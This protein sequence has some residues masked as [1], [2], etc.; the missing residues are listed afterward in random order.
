MLALHAT[1]KIKPGRIDEF[2]RLLGELAVATRAEPGNRLYVFG[3]GPAPD[4]VVMLERY[5]DRDALKAHFASAHFQAAG[6]RLADCFAEPP[7]SVR[8][9]EVQ[10]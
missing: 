6:Q 8:F 1:L 5:L 10:A 4:T 2:L 7:Q 3:R 9:D